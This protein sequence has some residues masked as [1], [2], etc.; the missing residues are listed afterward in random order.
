MSVALTG[1]PISA[2][3]NNDLGIESQRSQALKGR[4][5]ISKI[6]SPF[7]GLIFDETFSQGVAL[8]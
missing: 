5:N 2:Q 6:M 1:R 7:Q 8:G 3:G 4:S